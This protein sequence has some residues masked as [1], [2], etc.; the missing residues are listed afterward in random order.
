MEEPGPCL[1]PVMD[2]QPAHTT[3][4]WTALRVRWLTT[5]DTDALRLPYL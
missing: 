2:N 4:A 5:L 1:F 3:R